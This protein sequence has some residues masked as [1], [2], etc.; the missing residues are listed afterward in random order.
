LNL[1]TDQA[2]QADQVQQPQR[3]VFEEFA[4]GM[5]PAADL[6]DGTFSE[7]GLVARVVVGV[8]TQCFD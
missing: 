8:L 3:L 6:L 4:S 7:Q 1:L 2:L 5:D